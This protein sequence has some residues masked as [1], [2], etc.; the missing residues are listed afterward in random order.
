[1]RACM[2]GLVLVDLVFVQLTDAAPFAWLAPL[3]ALTILAPVLAPLRKRLAYRAAWNVGVLAVF[4]VL[5]GH[6]S[7]YELRYVLQDGLVLAALCHRNELL[8]EPS[9]R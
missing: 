4:C 3:Y 6:A 2:L 1:M 8:L 5:V 9:Q 7:G